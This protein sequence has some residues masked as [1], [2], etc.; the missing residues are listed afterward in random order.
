MKRQ[1]LL[2]WKDCFF[3]LGVAFFFFGC[4]AS[5]HRSGKT[6]DQG[7][8]SFSGSYLRAENMDNPDAEPIQ[9]IALDARVGL[10]RAVD[11]GAM[12]TWDISKG[13]ENQFAT[14]WGDFKVQVN[15]RDNLPGKPIFST[16]LIKGYVYHEGAELHIT[17]LPLIVS[18]PLNQNFT[19][20]LMYRHEFISSDFI[21]DDFGDPRST[22]V[23]G[24]EINL[25]KPT[26]KQWTPK[27]GL[28]I[29]T[30][31]SLTGCE[32]DGGFIFNLGFAVDS[33]PKRP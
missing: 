23:L 4:I 3:L 21:P 1:M 24:T 11:V 33:P 15:N 19:P 28:S 31:N 25:R 16:G 30:F 18:L 26:P 8:A 7:Q 27:V 20:Y 10:N 6:L 12:H 32:G 13:N 17:G 29:G 14:F 9:L 2:T 22:F 5:A